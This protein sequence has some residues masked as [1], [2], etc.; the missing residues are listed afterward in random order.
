[1]SVLLNSSTD[2]TN[3]A[4]E[5]LYDAVDSNYFTDQDAELIY[6]T[7]E[8][9]IRFISFGDYLRRYL[10]RKAGLTESFADVPVK[11][12]QDI[13]RD[14][15]SDNNTPA[16]FDQTTA[17]LSALT[18]NWLTQQ[19]VSR[20][21]VF[22]LGF[23]LAMSVDDVNEFLTKALREQGINAK[24]P[25][26]VICWYCLKNGYRFPKFERLWQI[27]LET[28]ANSLDVNLLYSDLTIGA[29]NTMFSIN[30]DAALIA[31]VSKLK[32][33]DNAPKLSIS[34]RSCFDELFK[35]AQELGA[36]LYNKEQAR[37]H[38][39]EVE[40]YRVKLQDDKRLSDEERLK[41]LTKKKESKNEYMPTDITAGDLE[42]IISSAI[43]VDRHGNLTPGK[44]SK[45]N[46]QFAGKRF[47]RQH[48]VEVLNGKAEV[49]RFDLITLNFFVYSQTLDDYPNTK[50][51]Y[52]SFIESTNKLLSRSFLGDLYIANPYEC[53]VL[54]C[55]L[56]E[57]PLG[58]YADVW[59]M[60]YE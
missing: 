8:K 50:S 23:G 19:T 29:R 16:S 17:K 49:S 44:A 4:W 45:L 43:P 34:A 33:P 46:A 28:P 26:E 6:R 25:F 38:D 54:M 5:A 57:D 52:I 35:K 60:S 20:K 36:E 41:R 2:F 53:F 14:S 21:V 3:N 27:Y 22:L 13:I 37:I 32:Q 9:K 7:L 47:N 12:Y 15:F 59:E 39:D 58:T 40:Q 48:I 24:S 31:F 51:R 30:N 42:H 10:Y 55:I 11:T 56:S 18:R 1:M